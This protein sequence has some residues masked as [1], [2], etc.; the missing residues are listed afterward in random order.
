MALGYSK[1][2]KTCAGHKPMLNSEVIFFF[3]GTLVVCERN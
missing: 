2:S 3:E 1:I